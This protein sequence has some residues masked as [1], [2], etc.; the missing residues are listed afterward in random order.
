MSPA[1]A[2]SVRRHALGWLVAANAVGLWLAA[3]LLWPDLNDLAAPLTYGRWVPLHLDWQLY[4]WCALPLVGALYRYYFAA[5]GSADR[6]GRLGLAL[7]TGALAYAGGTWLTGGASGKL[8]LNFAGPARV[9]WSLTLLALWALIAWQ[10]RKQQ[11]EA[12]FR[13]SLLLGL[14]A[15]PPLL[16]GAADPAVY[17]AVNPHSGGATG[18]SLLGS[19]LAL[20]AVFGVL[21]RLLR[22]E[23]IRPAGIY[24]R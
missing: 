7:W 4:G 5:A 10:G 17:P 22:L 24:W 8:F 2:A 19:T 14:L 9:A 6:A 23:K 16:Y 21:P 1:L 13:R 15:V 11:D 3:L 18:T 20:I 12:V